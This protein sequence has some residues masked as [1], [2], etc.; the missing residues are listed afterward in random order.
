MWTGEFVHGVLEEAYRHWNLNHTQFPWPYTPPQW[1]PQ[2]DAAIP[3]T[4]NIAS[5]G[6]RVEVRLAASGKRSRSRAAREA[7]YRRVEVAVNQLCPYLFPLITAAEERISGT[8]AM[9]TLA[10]GET[11]RGTRYELTGIV[12]VISSIMLG[13]S[14]TNP[15]VALIQS[16]LSSVSA[17]E[18]DLIVDYKAG[19]RP[20]LNSQF[21][22]QFE[23]Q[24]QTYAWLRS[25]IPQARPVGAGVLIYINELSPSRDDM[26]ELRREIAENTTDIVP[27]LGSA[28]YYAIQTW[29]AGQPA[30]ALSFDFRLLRALHIV[31]V[32]SPLVQHAV[33]QIDSVISQIESS[34]FREHNT[35]N[36]PNN[37]Q[38]CGESE[39]CAACDFVNFCPA[40]A[41]LRAQ[42]QQPS[43]LTRT[44]PLAPG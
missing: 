11:A 31:D 19:R 35:G 23:F 24:V 27:A 4:N 44:P 2:L 36:I 3:N 40:P 41:Q 39:D 33:G 42:L 34:A 20:G 12:D 6:H 29:Q 25:Q 9:P 1:P 43:P 21:R 14:D 38:A 37:W 13:A 18:Y 26:T 16:Q 10:T 22:T 28:D 5:F 8:R 17:G 7:A 32:A 15:L 30:P